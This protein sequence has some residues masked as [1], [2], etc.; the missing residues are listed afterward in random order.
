MRVEWSRQGRVHWEQDWL[1][2][3]GPIRTRIPDLKDHLSFVNHDLA[4][5]GRQLVT[6]DDEGLWIEIPEL[7]KAL[8]AISRKA[9]IPKEGHAGAVNLLGSNALLNEHGFFLVPRAPRGLRWTE[10][11]PQLTPVDAMYEFAITFIEYTQ[12]F[13]GR[14]EATTEEGTLS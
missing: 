1:N 3:R 12:R 14:P 9:E 5:N 10:G 4:H 6:E 11:G 13:T 2:A 7:H 8:I